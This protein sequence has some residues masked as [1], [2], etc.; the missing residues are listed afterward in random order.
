MNRW[1]QLMRWTLL[2]VFVFAA[3]CQSDAPAPGL[4][5]PDDSSGLPGSDATDVAGDSTTPEADSALPMDGVTQDVVPVGGD[6]GP[7]SQDVAPPPTDTE[8]DD[9]PP[10]PTDSDGDGV[11]DDDDC[12]PLDPLIFPGAEE[13]CNGDD[14]DCDEEIDEDMADLIC[15]EGVCQSTVPA[16]AFGVPVTCVVKDLATEEVCDALD[17]DCDGEIDEGFEV[18]TCGVGACENTIYSCQEGTETSCVP[19]EP[20]DETCNGIDDDCDGEVDEDLA[21]IACGVGVCATWVSGCVDGEVPI[22]EPLDVATDE[23]CD[24]LDNDCDGEVD[25]ELG[26]TTCGEGPCEIT[27]ANCADGAP[28]DCVP[29]ISEGTCDAPPAYCNETTSGADACGVPC[30]K[31]GPAQCYIVHAACFN[32]NPGAP[33]NASHC[34]TPKGKYNCGLTC[35]QWPNNIGADCTYC[36]N[37]HCKSKPGLDE[38]QFY[39][40]N[41]A[42]PPTE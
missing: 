39:C 25:E 18:L 7:D 24:G 15:G 20:D 3:G 5:F 17:N 35:Q 13:V 11:A 40:A 26:E 19:L 30:E 34:T 10:P 16:C 37:I 28:Q 14:D 9:G 4:S 1:T 23:I 22:C 32:S 36:V 2:L 12:A 8:A 33:T 29:P 31:V 41:Y 27:V 21:D 38:A 42:A 6:S